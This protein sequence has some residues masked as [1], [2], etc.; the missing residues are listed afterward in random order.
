MSAKSETVWNRR[1]A[2]VGLRLRKAMVVASALE[3]FDTVARRQRDERPFGVGAL[4]QLVGAPI[5]LRLARPVEGVHL[6]DRHVEDRFDRIVNLRFGRA[7]MDAKRV[8]VALEEGVTLLAHDGL[9]DDVTRVFHDSSP[10]SSLL[11][12][13]ALNPARSASSAVAHHASALV[14]L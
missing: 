3:Q 8:A 7:G 2:L 13:G 11:L 10:S 12:A 4:A 14:P 9:D 5:A 6:E 1:P